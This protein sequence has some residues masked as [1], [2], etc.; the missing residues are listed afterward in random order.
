MPK[1][2]LISFPGFEVIGRLAQHALPFGLGKR[3]LDEAGDARRHFLLHGK[4]VAEVAVVTFRPDVR[5]RNR[6]DQLRGN[7]HPVAALPDRALEHV[8][9]A[10]LATDLSDIDGAA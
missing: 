8:A 10:Q 2:A 1:A 6:V 4:D 9:Y 3:R 5:P 7:A